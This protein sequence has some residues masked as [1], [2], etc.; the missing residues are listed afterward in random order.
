MKKLINFILNLWTKLFIIPIQLFKC[1]NKNGQI[2]EKFMILICKNI[3]K[4]SNLFISH[5]LRNKFFTNRD[6]PK[7][8]N[9][10]DIAIVIQGPIETKNDFTIETVKY[11]KEAG[12]SN[13]IVSTW[14]SENPEIIQRLKSMGVRVVTSELPNFKGYGNINY[15]L[16][17]TQNGIKEAIKK[18]SKYICKTRSDQRIENVFS[19][20]A[21]IRLLNNYPVKGK[22]SLLNRIIALSTEYGSFYTPYYVSDFFYFGTS[23][24]MSKFLDIKLDNRDFFERKGM[25]RYDVANKKAISEVYIMRNLVEIMGNNYDCSI[26][27]YWDFIRDNLILI[28]KCFIKLYWPKYDTRYCEHIRNG[29]YNCNKVK[30]YL[31]SNIDFM[32]WIL[33]YENKIIYKEEYEKILKNTL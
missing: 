16:V 21:M 26:K 29:T 20:V 8:N 17:S 22:S 32:S 19:F 12:Y 18:N 25:S 13:I 10:D 28:D 24:D 33:L 1:K 23:E 11:Y 9:T 14:N 31:E 6:N 15:Q 2:T 7:F 5:T 27:D 4:K 30:K 3:E